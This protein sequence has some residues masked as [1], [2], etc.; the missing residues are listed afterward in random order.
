MYLQY[1]Q[2]GK[3]KEREKTCVQRVIQKPIITAIGAAENFE[4][5]IHQI[6]IKGAYSNGVLTAEEMIF[7]KQPRVTFTGPS[8]LTPMPKTGFYGVTNMH[9][10]SRFEG[11]DWD[12]WL[13]SSQNKARVSSHGWYVKN[14]DAVRFLL[15]LVSKRVKQQF[16]KNT[17]HPLLCCVVPQPPHCVLWHSPCCPP[18]K[19][20]I[21]LPCVFDP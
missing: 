15:V 20:S 12:S 5:Q 11:E 21:Y 2:K 7:M 17:V 13:C 6:D 19:V 3:E 9:V 18:C 14:G 10:S 16:K 1:N 8:P 4:I